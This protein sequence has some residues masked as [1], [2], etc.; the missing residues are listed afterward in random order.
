MFVLDRER[1][2]AG[3]VDA[4]LE[5]AEVEVEERAVDRGAADLVELDRQHLDGAVELGLVLV[6][7]AG[8]RAQLLDVLHERLADAVDEVGGLDRQGGDLLQ[9]AE[10]RVAVLLQPADERAER[11]DQPGQLLVAVADVVEHQR[12][13]VD[14]VADHLVA[15][16]EGRRDRRR[17]GEQPL[18][19]PALAL[20]HLD[21]L[22]RQLV[23]VFGESASNSGLKPLNSTVRSSAGV[24]RETGIVEPRQPP[25]V[26]DLLGERDV[27]LADEVAVADGGV[28]AAVDRGVAVDLEGDQRTGAVD[29]L[30]LADRAD[31][32]AGD[33]DVVAL[34]DA[35]G[36]GEL[37]LVLPA[38]PKSSVADGHHQ[39]RR[40]ERGDDDEDEQLDQVDRGPLVEDGSPQVTSAPRAIG[41]T[42]STRGRARRRR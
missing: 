9:R 28:G 38:A 32:D 13:V 24:V 27:A 26:A 8:H 3:Q 6:D 33:P 41:P 4:A 5:L 29:D 1:D 37:R 30:H 19:R 2:V 40:R 25:G 23:D 16:G 11:L 7:V 12:Q 15:V 42:S 21:D 35:G 36:V 31:P 39:H 17:V 18:Q 34:V 14:E 10:D 22:V 20:E